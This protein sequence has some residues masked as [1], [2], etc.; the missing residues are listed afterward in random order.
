MTTKT[1]TPVM[2]LQEFTVKHKLSPPEYNFR[3]AKEGSHENEFL[4]SVAV[5]NILAMGVGRSKQVAK[6]EAAYNAIRKLS[7]K[8]IYNTAEIP[9]DDFNPIL[10]R[11]EPEDPF[12]TTINS[13]GTL[14]DLCIENK[15][16]YPTYYEISDVGPPHCRLFTYECRLSSIRTEAIANT[17]KQAKQLAAKKMLDRVKEILPNGG[18]ELGEFKALP[19]D[20]FIE[21]YKELVP[22][23]VVP[24]KTVPVKDFIYLFADIME[25]KDLKFTDFEQDLEDASK[26]SLT[27]I[28][29]KLGL[30]YDIH[31]EINVEIPVVVNLILNTDRPFTILGFG[32]DYERAEKNALNQAFNSLRLL[33]KLK[34]V[35]E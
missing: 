2:C 7:D 12:Q 11:N 26:P 21:K 25:E 27:S 5:E 19:E 14:T 9:V 33:L 6:H 16:P 24:D 31:E 20:E 34:R 23:S 13:I 4:C 18:Q 28:T 35:K 30:E 15:I 10:H 22:F 32:E 8:G 29:N 3:N 17:K 1:K